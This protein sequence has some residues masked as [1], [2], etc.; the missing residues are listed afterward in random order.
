MWLVLLKTK[1][2]ALNA[3]NKIKTAAE[4]EVDLKLK[5]LRTDRGGELTSK[6]F[7]VYCEKHGINHFNIA[8]YSP[9]Q[10][11]VVERRNQM[12]VAMAR[13][14]LKSKNMP[15]II[16]GR[17][18]PIEVVLVFNNF[19]PDSIFGTTFNMICR[20]LSFFILSN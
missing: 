13:S 9:Q 20:I 8:P 11:G 2:Q 17:I 5:A 16:W 14:L 19:T 10:K 3:L 6:E 4:M 12:I 18:S 1:D 7:E 15:N